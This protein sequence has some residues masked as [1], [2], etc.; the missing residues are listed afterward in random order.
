M[1]A[2]A[3]APARS[4]TR[5]PFRADHVGSLL[6]PQELHEARTNRAAGRISQQ[7]LRAIEDR[8]IAQAIRKQEEVG[9][10][11]ATDGEFRRAYWHYD[12]VSGLRGVELYE[13]ENKIAFKGATLQ[14]ALRVT[15]P[16]AWD[17]PVFVDDYQ[18]T[19]SHVKTA[20][21]KQTIPS[22]SVVHFRGGR[23]AIDTHDLSGRWTSS[24]P[25][26]AAP[27][28]RR[29]DAFDEAGCRY[30][31]IDEVNIAYL[32]DPEQ[33]ENL[34]APR[35]ACRRPARHLCR[36]HQHR[37]RGPPFGH[38]RLHASLPRQF[39]LHLRGKGGYEPVADVLFNKIN[40]DGYFMEYDTERAGG[41]EPLR[42]VPKGN[43]V[44]V[45]GLVTSKTGALE[46]KDELKRRIEAGGEIR[47][48]RAARAL[49][50]MRLRQHGG[51]QPA[52]R[53]A[54][55]GEAPPLRRGCG[56]SLGQR[57]EHFHLR[58]NRRRPSPPP[59]PPNGIHP[60]ERL[61]SVGC[62]PRPAPRA[63]SRRDVV[64][65]RRG[66]RGALR[67]RLPARSRRVRGRWRGR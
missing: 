15:G 52:H 64:P 62:C 57:L 5:P 48:A 51:R 24:S 43:K 59:G 66:R 1:S 12:F 45:L 60:A 3:E 14:H 6:R 61:R 44:I 4:R 47:A 8:C 37:D 38:G 25:I 2:T 55:M 56:G 13:P 17:K 27:T 39:P 33:I 41:F 54:A 10:R 20:L 65:A 29:C 9:L 58:W 18:F 31:Q 23:G 50:A 30:L 42:F 7:E 35:R 11:A 32:C 53:G 40:V 28:P 19:A 63:G 26:S 36:P 46:S 16:I 22:P 67:C 49:P 34:Q 21:A